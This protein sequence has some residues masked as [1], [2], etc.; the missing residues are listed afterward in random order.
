VTRTLVLFAKEPGREARAKGFSAAAAADVFAAFASGWVDVAEKL[1]ARIVIATPA[2]DL[3]PWRR[4]RPSSR[5]VWI[6]QRGAS[7]GARLEDAVRRVTLPGGHV[8]VVGG[9]VAPDLAAAA[10]AFEAVEAGASAVLAPSADGGVSLLSFSARDHDLL[11]G[12]EVGRRDVFSTLSRRLAERGRSVALV[13]A[14]R[15]IDGRNDLRLLLRAHPPSLPLSL[16]RLALKPPA[17]PSIATAPAPCSR[18]A[19]PPSGLRA[20]PR[21]A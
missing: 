8:V 6:V 4:R 20:P 3:A 9:D 15:D 5:I 2:E 14:G 7:F 10:Q 16:A 18:F 12:V 19:G 11:S 21:A 13:S 17:G 1:G